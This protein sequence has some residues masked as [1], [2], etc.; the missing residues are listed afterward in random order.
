MARTII[1]EAG[2]VACRI[3]FVLLVLGLAWSQGFCA[4]QPSA[5]EE[6][7][8]LVKS[9]RYLE[10]SGAGDPDTGLSLCG[11]RCNSMSADYLNYTSP[12]GWR[13]ILVARDKEITVPLNNPFVQGTCA[14]VVDEYLV[15]VNDLYMSK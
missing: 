5:A 11:T 13:L 7:I 14:C 15:K 2:T 12:G 6:H 3:A 4:E 1:R 8:Y 10:N 9:Y